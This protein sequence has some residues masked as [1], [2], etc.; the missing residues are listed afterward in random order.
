MHYSLTLTETGII[1]FLGCWLLLNIAYACFNNK[2]SRYT[3]RWDIFR[4]IS[5]YQLFSIS[6]DRYRLS[7]R[8]RKNDGIITEW[9]I[10]PFFIPWKWVHTFYFPGNMVIESVR[11]KV[12][13][14]ALIAESAQKDNLKNQF[15]YRVVSGYIHRLPSD[16]PGAERQFKIERVKGTP[17]NETRT[18]VFISAFS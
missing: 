5:A 1:L 17:D 16:F 14:I 6:M 12:D 3:N 8:D 4:W 10:V 9:H 2:M 15:A 13:D 11:S 7:Y 18:D